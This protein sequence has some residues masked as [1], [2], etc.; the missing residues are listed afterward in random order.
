MTSSTWHV[1]F[2][3]QSYQGITRRDALSKFLALRWGTFIVFKMKS[4]LL[5]FFKI[6]FFNRTLSINTLSTLKQSIIVL[7]NLCISSYLP[8]ADF[9]LAFFI[10]HKNAFNSKHLCLKS[11][12]KQPQT[13]GIFTRCPGDAICD[14]CNNLRT[15]SQG[16]VKKKI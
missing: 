6:R 3:F 14:L 13:S 12:Q 15:S 8:L 16:R 10:Q 2:F 11:E 4:Y 1:E 9:A 7:T 5:E